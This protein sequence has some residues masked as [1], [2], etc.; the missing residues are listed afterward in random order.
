M[1]ENVNY[2]F[3]I[4]LSTNTVGGGSARQMSNHRLHYRRYGY[5][6]A[7]ARYQLALWRLLGRAIL[8]RPQALYSN[9]ERSD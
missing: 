6:H 5:W 8:V 2:L 4:P 7:E 3:A 9:F 1:I